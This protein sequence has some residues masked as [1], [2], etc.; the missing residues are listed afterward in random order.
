MTEDEARDA[1]RR[2]VASDTF[3]TVD[4]MDLTDLLRNARR[5]D[6]HGRLDVGVPFHDGAIKTAADGE[7]PV[8]APS[9]PYALGAIV[10]PLRRNGHAYTCIDAGTSGEEQP[11]FDLSPDS[12]TNDNDVTWQETLVA[13]WMPTYDL[14]AAAAMG[15]RW[16]AGKASDRITFGSQGDNYNAEQLYT[17]CIDMAKY[18]E[19]RVVQTI[20]T[21]SIKTI[22]LDVSRLPRAN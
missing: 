12:L 15:W 4:G 3:P 19:Q 18:Y 20:R 10:V 14:N 7:Y 6:Q 2:M 21:P 8:W 9:T 5:P 13:V 16:K 22:P 17:H 11:G 1:L